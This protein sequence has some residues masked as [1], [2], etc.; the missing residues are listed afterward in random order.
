[1]TRAVPSVSEVLALLKP[2]VAAAMPKTIAADQIDENAPLMEDGLGLDSVMIV[3]LIAAIEKSLELE[4]D[5]DDLSM[6]SFAS[7]RTLANVIVERLNN[8]VEG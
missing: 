7:L 1:M 4:F 3:G 5:D 6:R 2:I 8:P